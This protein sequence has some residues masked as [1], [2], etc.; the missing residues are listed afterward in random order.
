MLEN[1]FFVN[2]LVNDLIAGVTQ[3]EKLIFQIFGKLHVFSGASLCGLCHF[4]EPVRNQ[5]P[6]SNLLFFLTLIYMTGK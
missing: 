6:K 1:I 2:N 4:K 5:P 3:V